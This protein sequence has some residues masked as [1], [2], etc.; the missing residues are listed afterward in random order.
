MTFRVVPNWEKGLRHSCTF[1]DI[2]MEFLWG[3]GTALGKEASF[4]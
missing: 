4:K 3:R 1:V 2:Y